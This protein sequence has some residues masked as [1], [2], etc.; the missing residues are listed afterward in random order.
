MFTLLWTAVMAAGPPPA[1]ADFGHDDA[2]QRCR[3]ALARKVKG[4]VQDVTVLKFR[5]T[6]RTTLLRGE[7]SVFERPPVGELTPH[8]I[9][10]IRYFYDCRFTGRAAPRIRVSRLNN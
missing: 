8:H 2:V 10:N 7:M 9:I 4:E 6:K 5:K 1:M 3:P